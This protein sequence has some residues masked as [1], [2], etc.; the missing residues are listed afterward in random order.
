MKDTTTH[1]GMD[2]DA[3]KLHVAVLGPGRRGLVELT[4]PHEARAVRRLA[5]KLLREAPGEVRAC[6]E[7]GPTGF[8]LKRLMDEAGVSCEVIAPSL[9]PRK[10]GD[11]V[12]TDRRDA[13]KL[14]ELLQADLLTVVA[15]PLPEEEAVRDLCRARES[16]KED[17]TRC[18]HRLGKFLLRR[19]VRWTQGSSWTIRHRRWLRALRLEHAVD[20]GVLE[21]YLLA[22]EQVEERVKNLDEA[23]ARV[24]EQEPYRERV[25]WLCC[26]RGIGPLTAI[27]LVAELH[28]FQRFTSP[29]ELMSYLGLTPS[30][31]S[32]GQQVRRGG[33]TKAGNA[34][35]R[36]VLTEASWHARLPPRV[37]AGLKARRRGQPA[38][39]IALAD[40]AQARLHR[41]YWRLVLRGKH[42]AQANVAVGRELAG[43]VWA[44]LQPPAT[45]AHA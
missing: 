43:F 26:F 30:E 7:A 12:K 39:V 9:I 33:I 24:A 21:A 16:T 28:G 41:R 10:A 1:V 19:G 6:Y 4:V 34:H 27:T 11:R 23:L 8:A 35:V 18:R 40:K 15:P 14:A 17:L 37:G 36:R 20:Q 3:Q 22:V 32:S 31:R 45:Q 38:R 2:V 5:R 44:A 42:P 29:R 25:G 13:R